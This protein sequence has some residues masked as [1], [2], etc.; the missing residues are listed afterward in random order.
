MTEF[1]LE[2]NKS[3]FSFKKIK[4]DKLKEKISNYVNLNLRFNRG[5]LNANKNILYLD[6]CD[7]YDILKVN[8]NSD[9]VSVFKQSGKIPEVFVC[10]LDTNNKILK[11]SRKE[12]FY[13]HSLTNPDIKNYPNNVSISRKK[14]S[15]LIIGNLMLT[16]SG[17]L[18]PIDEFETT[19]I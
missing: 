6:Y 18:R 11:V 4:S 19:F 14:D 5:D 17:Y 15:N 16:F 12:K 3:I 1:Y 10:Y 13:T 9:V 7:F 8:Y 2:V